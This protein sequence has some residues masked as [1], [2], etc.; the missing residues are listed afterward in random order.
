VALGS[1]LVLGGT[2]A[3][4]PV[5]AQGTPAKLSERFASSGD[6]VLAQIVPDRTLPS[7]S[8]V[9]SQ[10]NIRVISEGTQAGSNLFHSFEEFSV[11]TGTEAYFNNTLDIQNI[12]SRVTGRSISNI[13]GLFRANG[14]ASLFLLNPN[15][16]IFGPNAK[17]DVGGSFV[18]TTASSFKFP[19]GSEFSATN[20]QAP[21]LLTINVTPGLQWGASTPGATITNTGNLAAGQDLSLVADFLDLQGQLQAGR[22]LTLL[23]QD[24]VQ[25]RDT[26]TTPLLAQASGNLTIQGNQ[27]IDILALNHPMQI[28]FVSGRNL[29]LIS[30]GIISLDARMSSGGSFS[31]TSVSGE[32]A[33][34][35]S[36]YDP[37]ISANGD[38]DVAANYTGASLLVEARG[39]IRFQGDINITGPDTSTL[40]PGP[41]TAILSTSSALIMRSGQST[42]AYG[43]ANSGAVPAY[44][45]E[46]VPAGITIGGNVILQPFNGTGGTVT[47][48]AASGNV[49]TQRVTTNGGAININ[50]AGAIAT[51]GQALDTRNGANNGGEITL[52]ANNG[53]ITTGNLNSDSYSNSGSAGNGGAIYLNAMGGSIITGDVNSSSFSNSGS[54]GNGGAI[55]M[56]A[57]ND[58]ITTGLLASNSYSYSSDTGGSGAAIT[59]QAANSIKIA[60]DLFSYSRSDSGNAA[61]GGAI[62]LGSTNGRIT[63]GDVNSS[64]FSTSGSAGNGGVISMSANN[65]S[66]TTGLLASNSYSYSSDTGGSGAAITLQAANSIK[67]T[68]D[69]SSYSLSNSGNATNGGAISLQ[70]TNSIKIAGD[71]FSYSR[72]DSGNAANGGAISLGSTNGRITTGDV[73]SSSFSTSGSAGN[74]GV[75]SMSA[76]NDSITTGLLASNSYSYSSDT[77]GSGAAITLQAANDIK[78]G[79]LISYSNQ[80]GTG[81]SG[82][83]TINSIEGT[84]N[85]GAVDAGTLANNGGTVQISAFRDI[86]INGKIDTWTNGSGNGGNITL[87]STNGAI[88]VTGYLDSRTNSGNGGNG[89][90]ITLSAANDINIT[91]YLH[92]SSVSDYR[93]RGDGGAIN[94]STTGGN[95]TTG[96]Y[97][98][99]YSVSVTGSAGNGGN[100]SLFAAKDININGDLSSDSHSRSVTGGN[101][102]AISIFTAGGSITTG[103]VLSDSY[104][105][106]REYSVSGTGGQGGAISIFA[107]NTIKTDAINST[108]AQGGN[109]T[110]SS[111]APFALDNRV[112]SSDTFGS[113]K[114]GDIQI[115]APAISL[116]GGAQI[117]AST[118]SSGRGGDITLR[119]SD[120]VELSG[121]TTNPPKGVFSPGFATISAGNYLGG[122]IPTGNLPVDNIGFPLPPPP[123]TIFPSGVFTQATIGSTGS[124]GNLRIETGRLS[125]NDGAAIATTTFGQGSNAG[126]ISVLAHD[127]ISIANGSLLSGVAGGARGDSGTI[128]LQTRSLSVTGGGVV[129]TQ[130]LGEGNAGAIRVNATDAVTISGI[131]T[132]SNPVIRSGLRSG[133]GGSNDLLG[134]TDSNIGQGGDISITTGIL[135]VVDGAVLDAQTQSNSSGGN[136]TVNANT[137]SA[138]NGG[139]LLTSTSGGGEAGDIT[140]SASELNLTGSNSGLFA[141]TTSTANAGNLTIQ[142]LGEGQNLTVNFRDGAQI[143]ASTSS[144]GNGGDLRI[145]APESITLTGNGSLISAETS[146][147]GTGGDLTLKTGTLTVNDNAQVTVSSSQTGNAGSITVEADAIRLDNKGKISADTSGGG[148]NIELRSRDLILRHG[149]SI[150]TNA[151]GSS[152]TGGNITIDTDNLVAVPNENSDISANAEDSFG[153]R[154]IVNASG[155]FGTQFR[156]A[157]TPL[158]DITASSELSPQFNG[159]VELNTPGIDLN[160]GL[161]NL[162]TAPVDTEVSQVC[163]AGTR[164][165]QNSFIITGRGGLPPNPRQ[166]LRSRAVEVDWVTLDAPANNL[167][168]DV[169]NRERQQ[170]RSGE[171]TSKSANNVNT[172]S[173]EIVEAQGWVVEANGNIILVATAPTATS[174][175][176]WHTPADCRTVESTKRSNLLVERAH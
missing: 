126:N 111:Y 62:S 6:Y 110:I 40:P 91:G 23:A 133:S 166:F 41:D 61:N 17:L 122:F 86:G 50:S 155:I 67:I 173:S 93:S 13:D 160:R 89:G 36:F 104:S 71:L 53:S 120:K 162:P 142:P 165:N 169:Q 108:G 29:S 25:V 2:L 79:D 55:S 51:N 20:P 172:Q 92:S 57:N 147:S 49:S 163:Q 136:I 85:T 128:D 116:T 12:F 30:D 118:H 35:V 7:N 76:N 100:I 18:A 176:S 143:S 125:I 87:T 144:R 174:H 73:N 139:Q 95:I 4:L 101:G 102:G 9:S 43:A 56:S 22:D 140:V 132:T 3:K 97:L 121:A 42:L 161:M 65:D 38:V 137:L 5:I 1:G 68:G 164:Q 37:I 16:I 63:T 171:Q 19:D 75:I 98:R 123:G 135:S 157:P 148:G 81:N 130:T 39:N 105:D 15:G 8:S 69:L 70:A 156:D 28:P 170:Q 152:I 64:S 99:S 115:T 32:L 45:T 84:V 82:N 26:V 146:G 21:P 11:P 145:T 33:N 27:G 149:S 88:A 58:S 113:G 60:G 106:L 114:G 134:T 94:L 129:Q 167:T 47:L 74:G 14:T 46:P 131:N 34:M 52:V 141:Q 159:T 119:V 175:S 78:T 66:I 80:S 54:A 150:T 10:D 24:T 44:G 158:S 153:G 124:G 77:G 154:V 117:S 48:S 151:R 112:I 107:A 96:G 127:S 59:L 83:I 31:L 109:I 72:S 168:E 138:V 103:Y 90:A